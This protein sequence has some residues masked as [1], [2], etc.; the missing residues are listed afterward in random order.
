LIMN[1]LQYYI[2]DTFIKNKPA[3]EDE[4]NDREHGEGEEDGLLTPERDGDVIEGIDADGVQK[5]AKV[6]SKPEGPN[7][8]SYGA[9]KDHE[10]G[11]PAGE[12][13]S[14]ASNV[15]MDPP[16]RKPT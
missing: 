11:T 6:T 13:S 4:N 9:D 12:S 8:K 10:P 3:A 5:E 2:I 1:A 16:T 15:E 7:P 14:S